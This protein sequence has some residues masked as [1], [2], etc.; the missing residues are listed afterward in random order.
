MSEPSVDTRDGAAISA[1][2]LLAR[3]A[4]AESRAQRSLTHAIDDLFL[5]DESRLDERTRAALANVLRAVVDA[6]EA[7]LRA[8]A[9]RLLIARDQAML[10]EALTRETGAV[11]ARLTT[12]GLLRDSDLMTELLARV[13]QEL[14]AMSIPAQAPDEPERASLI[15]RLAQHPDP[16][17][18]GAATA[19]LLAESR[20]R[21]ILET[22]EQ[23]GTDLS[24]E[25]H[26]RLVWWTAATLREFHATSGE[27]IDALDRALVDAAQRSLAAHDEGER[28]EAASM[29]LAYAIDPNADE[30]PDLLIEALGDR[31]VALFTA[32]LAQALRVGYEVARDIV[33]DPESERLWLVLRALDMGREAIA[34]VGYAL[35]QA[36]PR[37]DLDH[38]ADMIDAIVDIDA[39]VAR[40]T[41]AP[42]R[43][44]AD[45]RAA[46]RAIEG[47][48]SEGP[49][50]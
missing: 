13:R 31:R 16:N 24:A 4:A 10:A 9:A 11:F 45:Y 8:H 40:A 32:L 20:R 38:F 43:L 25:L 49:P 36:D 19:V 29:R 50:A 3:A 5:P 2:R 28:L 27:S 35:C 33:F 22:G 42:L 21:A 6:V 46:I 12:S 30:L 15:S 37:R 17:L 14:I 1:G 7:D 41:L 18:A 44:P 23:T 47:R 39:G 26:H 48:A 34:R